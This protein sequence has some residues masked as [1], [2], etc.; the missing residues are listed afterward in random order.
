MIEEKVKISEIDIST[1]EMLKY[2]WVPT[3]PIST[4]NRVVNTSED[5]LN[6]KD[7]FINKYGSVGELFLVF[8]PK[9]PQVVNN[10]VVDV[11]Y[12]RVCETNLKYYKNSIRTK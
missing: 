10:S 2:R 5:L 12:K 3:I 8:N 6:W 7:D 4:S 9:G 11:E 1:F